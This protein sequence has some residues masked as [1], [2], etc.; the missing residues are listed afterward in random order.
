M[1]W[2]GRNRLPAGCG[3]IRYPR[4]APAIG[5]SDERRPLQ[6]GYPQIPEDRRRHLA[7]R[8]RAGGARRPREGQTVGADAAQAE[9]DAAH[10]GDRARARHR[11]RDRPELITLTPARR[12]TAPAA[13]PYFASATV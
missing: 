11:R 5:G 1:A 9:D 10:P 4:A 6:H 13:G 3:F 7:A 8:D 2:C 12:R